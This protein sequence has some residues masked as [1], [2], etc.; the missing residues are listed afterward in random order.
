MKK[1]LLLI[2]AL[3][4][5]GLAA[6][7]FAPPESLPPQLRG[8][9]GRIA[10]LL[11]RPG[12]G[13]VPESPPGESLQPRAE[14]LPSLDAAGDRD[15]E[16]GGD[17]PE[18]AAAGSGAGH[19]PEAGVAAPE[20]EPVEEDSLTAA[21]AESLQA[22]EALRGAGEE[23]QVLE[24]EWGR[25]SAGTGPSE[26]ERLEAFLAEFPLHALCR[27]GDRGLAMFGGHILR[28]GDLLPGLEAVIVRIDP[29]RVV[30]ELE[31]EEIPLGLPPVLPRPPEVPSRDSSG[32]Q[33]VGAA[34]TQPSPS[35]GPDST[36]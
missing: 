6:L 27:S 28:P 30:L 31:G 21:L 14:D 22:L 29:D 3:G 5:L 7:P 35:S 18:T 1:A 17:R 19:S 9:A 11:G 20:E 26:H 8:V 23:P 15:A 24:E 10:V 16:R 25:W 33:S 34:S 36:P 12:P 13:E 4:G 32:Q 2:P